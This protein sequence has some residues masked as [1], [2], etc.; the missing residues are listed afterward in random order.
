M[1][2]YVSWNMVHDWN[3]QRLAFKKGVFGAYTNSEGPD[4]TAQCNAQSDLDLRCPPIELLKALV[5]I[6]VTSDL[7]SLSAYLELYR[8]RM[9][10]IALFLMEGRFI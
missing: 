3:N 5:Y 8:S 1:E 4:Q 9:P 6:D 2:F 7:A 10:W